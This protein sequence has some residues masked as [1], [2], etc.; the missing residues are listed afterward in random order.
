M[1][2]NSGRRMRCGCGVELAE[3]AKWIDEMTHFF[4]TT[5]LRRAADFYRIQALFC[6]TWGIVSQF[7][8]FPHRPLLPLVL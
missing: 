2:R 3:G 6:V 7:S 1:K 4:E 5:P 8:T